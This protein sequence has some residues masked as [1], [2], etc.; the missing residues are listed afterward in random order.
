MNS[1][2]NIKDLTAYAAGTIDKQA[3]DAVTSHLNECGECS[4]TVSS[5]NAI[6]LDSDNSGLIPPLRV[7]N[8]VL[9][10]LNETENRT[11]PLKNAVRLLLRPA[12]YAAFI[13][14]AAASIYLLS[15]RQPA[16]MPDNAFFSITRN[17]GDVILNE[18]QILKNTGNVNTGEITTKEYS[19]AN[20][21]LDSF[22]SIKITENTKLTIIESH[23]NI[24]NDNTEYTIALKLDKGVISAE[25]D[26]TVKKK[27]TVST[28]QATFEA[29]GTSFIISTD[30][31]SSG[32]SVLDGIVSVTS[33]DGKQTILINKDEGCVVTDAS[34]RKTTIDPE[35]ENRIFLDLFN[36]QKHYKSTTQGSAI[37]A[38]GP[39]RAANTSSPD[40]NINSEYN[41]SNTEELKK[42]KEE[43]LKENRQI[44]KDMRS[45][46]KAGK[47]TQR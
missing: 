14:I 15:N 31:T 1:H 35:N 10:L 7:K 47:R 26:H 45:N 4:K 2:P 29:L 44:Q 39:D 3:S 9:G 33:K 18:S 23:K 13:I 34:M 8:R 38:G 30:N 22:L 43:M 20:L 21:S 19:S 17:T 46:L 40:K 11:M 12:V 28:E 32:L 41:K 37:Q 27:F 25:T 42:S 5:L 36:K 6:L 16:G 24:I